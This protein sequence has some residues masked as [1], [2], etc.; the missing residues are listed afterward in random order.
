MKLSLAVFATSFAVA[1]EAGSLEKWANIR[2][3]LSYEMVAGYKPESQVT[4]HCAIDLDQAAMEVQLAVGT[5]ESFQAARK[6]YNTGG[7]SKVYADV[8]IT[9]AL[10][11]TIPKGDKI[12]GRG[13]EDQ[14]VM[15]KT[16]AAYQAGDSALKV[17][18]ATTDLQDSYVGCQ[19]GGLVE[20]TLKGCFKETGEFTIGGDTYTYTYD[21]ATENKAGRTISGFS[22]GAESK[23]LNGCAGCPYKHFSYFNDYYGKPTY[24]HEWIEA[25]YEGRK[26]NLSNGNADFSL[27]GKAGLEQIIK[28]GT[29]YM[30]ILMYVQ[31]EFEDAMDDCTNQ[32]IDDN[33]NSVHAWDEGVCFYAGS[34]E[35]QDGVSD[36]GKLLHQVADKRCENFKTCGTEG[37]DLD[38][39]SKLN[40][41]LMDLFA[42]GNEQI[43]S[44]NCPAA[45]ETTAR[46]ME[47]MYVPMIQGALRYAYKVDKLD[48]GEKEAAEGVAFSAGVLPRIHAASS[49]AA[50][51]IYDNTKV[52]ASSTDFAEVK[53]AFESVYA[54]MGLTCGDIGGLWN[55]G[56]KDY[57]PGAEP[58]TDVSTESSG[59][60]SMRVLS[61]AAVALP[62]IVLAV[63]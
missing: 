26:T 61:W 39:Q 46:I 18:Y 29:V 40:Y 11:K 52:G 63:L 1:A 14:E 54:D 31:R 9:P 42:L 17:Y 43:L 57:Y 36:D 20:P 22:T 7:N 2:R 16:G 56:E 35:G 23:M 30:N 32:R 44:G 37:V 41:D 49:S 48:G 6:I 59:S 27:Y 62:A 47:L 5:D 15:G 19:V 4:D 60:T 24:A 10:T 33:Y 28:K 50:K 25:A 12:M 55:E 51:T 45:K 58:C 13:T 34:K 8:T 38:G 53:V 21:P 3:Q